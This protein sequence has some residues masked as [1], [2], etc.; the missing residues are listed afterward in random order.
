MRMAGFGLSK[1]RGIVWS[2]IDLIDFR[3]RGL[4]ETVRIPIF[5]RTSIS[6]STSLKWTSG[7]Y[8]AILAAELLNPDSY[9]PH[10]FKF[11]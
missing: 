11:N 3:G 1:V 10:V 6:P 5:P 7:H 8:L 9:F 4:A 2:W